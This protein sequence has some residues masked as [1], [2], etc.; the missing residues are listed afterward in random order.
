MGKLF[1]SVAVMLVFSLV[2]A[3][4]SLA[5][6]VDLATQVAEL[7]ELVLSQ[8]KTIEDQSRRIGELEKCYKGSCARLDEYDKE[9]ENI[10]NMERDI[11]GRLK[12][13]MDRLTGLGESGLDIGGGITVVGQGTP[14]AN[15]A[16]TTNGRSSRFDGSY[17]ADI[18]IAKQFDDGLA[19]V[20]MEAGQGDTIEGELDVFSNVNRDAGDTSAHFDLTEAWYEH[21]FFDGQYILTGGKLDATA[22]MDTNEFA[23]DE[24]TQYLGGIFRNSPTIE[25]PDDNSFGVRVNAAPSCLE[26]M[27]LGIVYADADG[28]W[29]N[30]FDEG[31]IG[32]QLSVSTDKLLGHD[33]NEWKGNIRAF[34]WYNAKSHARIKDPSEFRRGN[35]GFGLNFDQRI[36]EIYGVFG[37]FGWADPKVSVLEF[38]W[39]LGANMAGKYWNRVDDIV[40][41]A[42]GQVIPGE[43]Y[44]DAGNPDASETHLEAYYAYKINDHITLSPDIQLIWNPGG[45]DSAAEGDDDVI[46]VYGVRGQVD[47]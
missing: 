21:Y 20:H 12:G 32:T 2:C 30:I 29:E 16:D 24:T 4:E 10:K 18:E 26:W 11:S 14:N 42:V 34:F 41:V 33:P 3:G 23:N 40:A 6:D 45:V 44:G 1:N 25:F 8:Q 5:A 15:N 47:F 38:D 36:A 37:R 19:F 17:S 43:E 39:S 9:F 46:F 31:F 35:A 28:D 13:Q 27:E 7:K 22:Y